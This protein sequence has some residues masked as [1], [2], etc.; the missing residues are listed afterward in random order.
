MPDL[1]KEILNKTFFDVS[2]QNFLIAFGIIFAFILLR[3]PVSRMILGVLKKLAK[4]TTSTIDDKLIKALEDPF[5][6]SFIILGFYCALSWLNLK[7]LKHFFTQIIES[8]MVIVIFWTLYRLIREFDAIIAVFSSRLG[9]PL[10]KDIENFIIK[11]LKALIIIIGF[12][13][14][15]QSWGINVTT[16]IASLGLGG[17][18]FALAAK[19]TAANLFGSLVIFADRPFQVGDWVTIDGVEGSIEEIGIRSTRIRTTAQSLVT[20]PN[21]KVANTSIVNWTRRG[22]RCARGYIGLT[23]DTTSKQIE[24]ILQDFQDLF[25]KHE[26]IYDEGVILTFESFGDSSLNILYRYYTKTTVYAE[27]VKIRQEINIAFMH[28]VEKHGSSFA[29]PS[30]SLYIE[31]FPQN[32]TKQVENK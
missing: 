21:A 12:L 24:A 27:F 32:I 19:D 7:G 30:Q 17:L 9:K 20:I 3:T 2:V 23:Y 31:N 4:K 5:R 13:M 15:L 6:F 16:F 28:I 26:G 18:A 22:K 25:D 29:F 14:F 11:S 8:L 10:N 1:I